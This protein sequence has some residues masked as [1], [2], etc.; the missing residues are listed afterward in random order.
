MIDLC[1]VCVD[2]GAGL[3]A[4]RVDLSVARGELLVLVGESGCGKTTTLKTINRL[5]APSSG[6]VMFDGMDVA[7]IPGHLLRRRIG[8]V[9]QRVGLFPH[10]DVEENIGLPLDLAEYPRQDRRRRVIEMLELVE[11]GEQFKSRRVDQLSGG[12]Q[13]RVAVARALATEPQLLLFDEPFS[14]L[15]PLTRDILQQTLLRL[16]SR[17]GFTAVFV[18]H[19]MSEALLLGDRVAVMREGRVVQQGRPIDLVNHP[20]DQTVERLLGTPRRQAAAYERLR[21][22]AAP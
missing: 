1:Q 20:V 12:Q 13:Q 7:N 14:A 8:Y 18:T 21:E 6:R 3:V 19:D 4:D 11:L 2:F 9:L 16:R 10:L 17:L 5:V 15:D 22:Q